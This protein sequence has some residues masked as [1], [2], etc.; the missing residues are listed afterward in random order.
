MQSK[1]V[2]IL[3]HRQ[4]EL[5]TLVYGILSLYITHT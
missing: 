5:F 4:K 1:K 3:T 2:L